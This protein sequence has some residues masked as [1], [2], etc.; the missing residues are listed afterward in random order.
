LKVKVAPATV[1]AGSVS[2]TGAGAAAP[3]ASKLAEPGTGANPD[4]RVNATVTFGVPL[5]TVMVVVNVAG[6][7]SGEPRFCN[8]VASRSMSCHGRSASAN[9]AGNRSARV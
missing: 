2:A 8:G 1:T 6:R 7:T 9:S 5:A 3:L 4:G